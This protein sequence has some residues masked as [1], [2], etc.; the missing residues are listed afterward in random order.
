MKRT[1]AL[2]RTITVLTTAAVI[3]TQA[4]VPVSRSRAWAQDSLT[5][6]K[7][8]GLVPAATA[9]SEEKKAE[10]QKEAK[11]KKSERPKTFALN[12]RDSDI[13]DF[14]NFMSRLIGKNIIMDDNVRGK[15]SIISNKE[16]P[17]SEAFEVTKA[18]L[19]VKGLA[20]VETNNLLKVLPIRDAI[21]KNVDIVID[22]DKTISPGQQKTVTFLFELQ[23]ADAAQIAQVL[24][25]L[26]S[27][28]TDIVVYPVLNTII[29]SGSSTEI[30][31]LLKVARALDKTPEKATDSKSAKGNIHVV[32]LQYANAEELANVLSRVPFSEV[33]FVNTEAVTPA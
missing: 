22:G 21:K 11:K 17:V 5:A 16:V 13:A 3:I 27:Q 18:I 31:G 9:K 26:K 4:W 32:S 6:E 8:D 15:I 10:P 24:Q 12:F 25:P 23:N 7:S 1:D 33:A 2:T 14:L 29:F 20:I 30:E 19:E 28:F